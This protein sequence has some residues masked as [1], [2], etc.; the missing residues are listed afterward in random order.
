MS[1]DQTVIPAHRDEQNNR[2]REDAIHDG[3]PSS[4]DHVRREPVFGECE[5]CARRSYTGLAAA[6]VFVISVR[7]SQNCPMHTK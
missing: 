5:E 6:V 4:D 3:P 2:S 7:S 1:L